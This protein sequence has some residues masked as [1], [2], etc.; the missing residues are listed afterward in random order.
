MVETPPLTAIIVVVL[1][2]LGLVGLF[3]AL[4]PD[5]REEA[6]PQERAVDLEIRGDAMSPA[7]IAVSED[8]RVT[9]GITADRPIELHLH[10]YDLEEEVSAGEPAEL[11]FDA[12]ITGRFEIENHDTETELGALIVEPHEGD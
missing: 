7:E 10:G 12:D 3:F 4:R 8:D 9:L 6:G 5:A 1:V 11:S 2:I